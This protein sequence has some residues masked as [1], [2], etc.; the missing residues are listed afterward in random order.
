MKSGLCLAA[1]GLLVLLAGCESQP[2]AKN[3]SLFRDIRPSPGFDTAG[4]DCA[5]RLY[6]D[7]AHTVSGTSECRNGATVF[8]SGKS[9]APLAEDLSCD[10]ALTYTGERGGTGRIS[11]TDGNTG[12]FVFEETDSTHG[13]A[14]ARMKDGRE[15]KLT[16]TQ[17]AR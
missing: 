3:D 10:Y 12:N 11:C 4:A 8:F 7:S 17:A 5:G 6:R 13:V 1:M 9:D 15:I 14:T 2:E 16:Y